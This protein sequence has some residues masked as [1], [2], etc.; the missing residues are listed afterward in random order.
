[1]FMLHLLSLQSDTIS[2]KDSDFMAISVVG[3]SKTYLGLHVNV[4][5]CFPDFNQI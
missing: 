2:L 4:P 3:N 5:M 1:M